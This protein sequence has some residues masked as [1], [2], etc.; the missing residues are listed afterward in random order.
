MNSPSQFPHLSFSLFSFLSQKLLISLLSLSLSW[1]RVC[2]LLLFFVG[3]AGWEK[4]EKEAAALRDQ[5]EAAA[6]NNSSLEDRVA[7]LD[8]ALKDCLRQ[9]RLST[10]QQEERLQ[11]ALGD[12]ADQWRSEKFSLEIR[13]LELEA[14]LEAAEKKIAR[15][16]QLDA[17]AM[18]NSDLRLRILSLAEQLHL[19]TVESAK[20]VSALEAECRR[21][22]AL[23]RESSSGDLTWEIDLMDD[24]LEMERL[25]ASPERETRNGSPEAELGDLLE[26]TAELEEKAE[27]AE[28]EKSDM[29][30]LLAQARD[31]LEVT[32]RQPEEAERKADD[33]RSQ[34]QMTGDSRA[35]EL[36][37]KVRRLEKNVEQERA[38]SAEFTGNCQR[39]EEEEL[40]RKRRETELRRAAIFPGKLKLEQVIAPPLRRFPPSF[41]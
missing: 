17:L 9:L 37:E 18:E 34:S 1:W 13:I 21:L 10:E 4:A 16:P 29:G 39:M 8:G 20:K 3:N 40:S 22:Q 27:A 23:A 30:K 25:V 11:D 15:R 35:R 19:Q 5:L 33:L 38:L 12:R 36:Q 41:H 28:T 6:R 2:L 7:Q 24:F 14:Q 26:R 31:R 32:Q